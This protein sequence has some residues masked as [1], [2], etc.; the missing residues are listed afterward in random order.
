[1]ATQVLR[2]FL[3][4]VISDQH[5]I[6]L[7]KPDVTDLDPDEDLALERKSFRAYTSILYVDPVMQVYI[8]NKKV[9]FCLSFLILVFLSLTI[10]HLNLSAVHNDSS[11]VHC[12]CFFSYYLPFAGPYEALVRHFVSAEDLQILF[13]A[14]Q[15]AERRRREKGGGGKTVRQCK[16]M[17]LWIIIDN[18]SANR[19]VSSFH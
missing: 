14:I 19:K 6:I 17:A 18:F 8:N 15:K 4:D 1:M 11:C 5:D 9:T 3:S 2:I 12:T 7:S 13:G 10:D 16:G